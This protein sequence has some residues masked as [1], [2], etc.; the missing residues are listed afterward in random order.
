MK[1]KIL[2]IIFLLSLSFQCHGEEYRH[3]QKAEAK[4]L[5]VEMLNNTI[6]PFLIIEIT[7]TDGYIQFYNEDPGILIDLPEVAL[8]GEQIKKAKAYFAKQGVPL[9][10]TTARNPE[11]KEDFSLKTWNR[12]F[13]PNEVDKVIDIAFGALIEI[14]GISEDTPLNFVKGWE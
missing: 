8:S 13:H 5:L 1:T 9:T 6:D 3:T 14:Y 7:G 11:T 10:V 12:I 2:F 4:A